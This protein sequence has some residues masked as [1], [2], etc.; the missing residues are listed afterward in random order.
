V[1]VT[2]K[3]DVALA[4]VGAAGAGTVGIDLEGGGR[5]PLNIASK[6]LRADELD[7][8]HSL[9]LDVRWAQLVRSFALKE[10]TYKAIHPH[11]RRYVS[12]HE[13]RVTVVPPRVELFLVDSSVA[14]LRLEAVIEE[15][16]PRVLAMVRAVLV[17]P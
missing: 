5:E 3:N 12:F 17:K 2:H 10:A 9:P 1:S 14:P 11:V 13:A 16:G 7:A 6:V 15:V 4:L 8:L